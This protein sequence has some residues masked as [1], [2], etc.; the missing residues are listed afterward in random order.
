[1]KKL[2][3]DNFDKIVMLF[4]FTMIFIS[5]LVFQLDWLGMLVRDAFLVLATLLGVRRPQP[6]QSGNTEQGD[7][8]NVAPAD[9]LKDITEPEAIGAVEVLKEED[10]NDFRG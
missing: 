5:G 6:A 2:F 9:E 7:V 4:V 8:Y 10:K 3:A 1:M